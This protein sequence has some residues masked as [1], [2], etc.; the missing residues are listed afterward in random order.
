MEQ[1]CWNLWIIAVDAVPDGDKADA[2]LLKNDF[3]I[4]AGLR[5]ISANSLYALHQYQSHFSGFNVGNQPLSRER[6]KLP[7]A[8]RHRRS[9]H[10]FRTHGQQHSLQDIFLID[11]RIA[12]P[13]QVVVTR[14][15]PV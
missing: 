11:N 6:S 9:G 14:E 4:E 7:Q 1:T 10:S 12:A 15:S 5:I 2:I 8:T 13:S 3:R